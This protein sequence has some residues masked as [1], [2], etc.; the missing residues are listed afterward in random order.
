MSRRRIS[1][2]IVYTIAHPVLLTPNKVYFDPFIFVNILVTA[3]S[4]C[5]I[6]QE[7]CRIKDNKNFNIA[8]YIYMPKKSMIEKLQEKREIKQ[9]A[10]K[11]VIAVLGHQEEIASA[12]E[13]GFNMQEIYEV[14]VEEGKMPVTYAAFTRLV[15]KYIKKKENQHKG[16]ERLPKGSTESKEITDK[17]KPHIFNPD[18][19]DKKNLF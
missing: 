3:H 7:Y 15:N 18:D 13:K 2:A 14:M 17:K 8:D 6:I 4:F 9:R 11:G 16:A 1:R 10:N 5:Y 19:Y 12:L